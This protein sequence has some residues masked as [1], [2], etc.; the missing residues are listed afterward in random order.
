MF[1]GKVFP[2]PPETCLNFVHNQEDSM[3]V[4]Y[5]AKA[6]QKRR[7]R[8]EVST[9]PENRL[10]QNGCDV[11]GTYLLR[12]KKVELIERF[13]DDLFFRRRWGQGKLMPVRI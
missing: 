4:T 11:L 9:L 1:R 10:D 7:R 13:V 5:L 8:R 3:F 6:P 12:E 2:G